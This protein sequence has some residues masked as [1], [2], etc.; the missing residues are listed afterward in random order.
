LRGQH[1]NFY[2]Q[3]IHSLI[4]PNKTGLF[5]DVGAGKTGASK[6][7]T[8]VEWKLVKGWMRLYLHPNSWHMQSTHLRSALRKTLP[9][10]QVRSR[11][12]LCSG[13]SCSF[14]GLPDGINRRLP[15]AN[16]TTRSL[17][18]S[19]VSSKLMIVTAHENITFPL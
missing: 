6:Q 9:G 16:Q 8:P 1:I 17:V 13:E 3:V 2:P 11:F 18:S 4:S 5:T 12:C 14:F 15:E 10:G 19:M 7:K